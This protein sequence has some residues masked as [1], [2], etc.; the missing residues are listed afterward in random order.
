LLE[1]EKNLAKR[2]NQI[3]DEGTYGDDWERVL[4]DFAGHVY[5]AGDWRELADK[6][7]VSYATVENIAYRYTRSPHLRTVVS[8]M[9]ALGRGDELRAALATNTPLSE[10]EALKLRPAAIKRRYQKLKHRAKAEKAARQAN[11][12][13]AAKKSK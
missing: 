9:D 7:G 4:A 11:A 3:L 1:K 10:A 5:N 8:I 6:A 12:K 13:P 2:I